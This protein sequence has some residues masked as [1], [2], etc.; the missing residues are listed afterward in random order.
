M[1]QDQKIKTHE[2][3]APCCER[4][5]DEWSESRKYGADE[6]LT[7][8]WQ[9]RMKN[10]NAVRCRFVCSV[11]LSLHFKGH[12]PHRVVSCLWYSSKPLNYWFTDRLL[13]FYFLPYTK[14]ITTRSSHPNQNSRL[15]MFSF[16]QFAIYNC[17][18]CSVVFI[19]ECFCWKC[20]L[21]F[22]RDYRIFKCKHDEQ[23]GRIL[24]NKIEHVA[25]HFH[26]SSR[27][28]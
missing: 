1:R 5:G 11:E 13:I 26:Y 22:E 25:V 2:T 14:C 20:R 8:R 27:N 6:K 21:V 28:I 4:R 16:T 23:L 24:S 17:N 10:N 12:V 19:Y 3:N 9:W 7:M 18:R 15:H